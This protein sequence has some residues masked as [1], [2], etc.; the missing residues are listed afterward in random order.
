M[1][2]VKM[3]SR[4]CNSGQIALPWGVR[5]PLFGAFGM[6]NGNYARATNWAMAGVLGV[7]GHSPLESSLSSISVA[8]W[9]TQSPCPCGNRVKTEGRRESMQTTKAGRHMPKSAKLEAMIRADH[10]EL[11]AR[12]PRDLFHRVNELK[13]ILRLNGS[14]QVRKE[15]GRRRTCRLRFRDPGARDGQFQKSITVPEEAVPGVQ[16]MLVGFQCEYALEVEAERKRKRMEEQWQKQEEGEELHG[17]L[18]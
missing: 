7:C 13:P 18:C 17:G 12:I 5:A 14:I 9:G 6:H 8:W 10:R 2:A 11:L 15:R 16:Q 1:T 3:M 4:A